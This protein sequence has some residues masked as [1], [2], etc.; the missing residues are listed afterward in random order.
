MAVWSDANW[1]E[2]AL[3]GKYI[4]KHD[5]NSFKD[6][7][8][9]GRGGF[10]DVYSAY[11]KHL[12]NVALKKLFRGP[13]NDKNSVN[14][15]IRELKNIT[16]IAQ[17]DN[18]VQFLGITL[19]SATTKYCIVLKYANDKDLRSYL[20]SR[21]SDLDWITKIRMATEIS[22]GID[23]LHNE[24]IVHRDLVRYHFCFI[25]YY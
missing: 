19:D 1:F 14:E 6:L 20:Q 23:W 15:F 7:K 11:S 17:H 2:L 24:N 5:Y 10:G 9:I 13:N 25:I 21:F 12:G 18:I 16:N 22:R 4:K 3:E 8:L